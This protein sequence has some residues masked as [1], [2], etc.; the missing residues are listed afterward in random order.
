MIGCGISDDLDTFN[1]FSE[2]K[3]VCVIDKRSKWVLVS[4]IWRKYLLL[5]IKRRN[6]ILFLKL[7]FIK[8]IPHAGKHY[9]ICATFL[10]LFHLDSKFIRAQDCTVIKFMVICSPVLYIGTKQFA[11]LWVNSIHNRQY[12][13]P[14]TLRE[15]QA[16]AVVKCVMGSLMIALQDTWYTS[17]P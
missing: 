10:D 11:T 6:S 9:E 8:W 17:C 2:K 12:S 16:Y 7:S 15:N 5:I 14:V 3:L 4:L 1:K 13:S